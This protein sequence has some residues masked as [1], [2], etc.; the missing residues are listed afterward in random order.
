VHANI[1]FVG[2][3][4]AYAASAFGQPGF[5]ALYGQRTPMPENWEDECYFYNRGFQRA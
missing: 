3:G 1:R 4:G 5:K 2:V